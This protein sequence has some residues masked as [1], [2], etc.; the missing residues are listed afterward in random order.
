MENFERERENLSKA[1][2]CQGCCYE[3]ALCLQYGRCWLCVEEDVFSKMKM[4]F[5]KDM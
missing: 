5:K 1:T 3:R 2:E 4:F